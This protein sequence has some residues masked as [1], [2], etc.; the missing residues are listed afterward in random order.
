MNIGHSSRLS[1]DKSTYPEKLEESVSPLSYRINTNQIYNNDRCL[2][3]YGPRSNYMGH[4]VSTFTDIGRA[5]AQSLTDMDSIMSNRNVKATRS[6]RGNVNPVD[7]LQFKLH[8]A[9]LCNNGLIPEHTRM[10]HPPSNYRDMSVNR[11]YNLLH[12]PQE[13]IF[14][15]FSVNTRLEAKDNFQPDVPQPW[16]DMAGPKESKEEYEVCTSSCSK[17][18]SKK[19]PIGWRRQ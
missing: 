6:R 13:H 19:C 7:P 1:Y 17:Q 8:N 15:D 5:E 12:D 18:S 2:S 3:I 16:P 10:S 4:G 9:K 14:V 11:F